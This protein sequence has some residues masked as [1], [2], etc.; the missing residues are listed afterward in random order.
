MIALW[1][2]QIHQRRVKVVLRHCSMQAGAT[3]DRAVADVGSKA[4]PG[5]DRHAVELEALAD[6]KK[7]EFDQCAEVP[8]R[9]LEL[10][11]ANWESSRLQLR[12]KQC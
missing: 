12:D 3:K 10:H 9:P 8:V 6:S 11:E 1:G 4:F 2:T 7:V 5:S